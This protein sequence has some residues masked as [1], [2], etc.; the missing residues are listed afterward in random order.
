[1]KI[2]KLLFLTVFIYWFCPFTFGNAQQAELVLI[3]KDK[4][5]KEWLINE[6]KIIKI[7]H[8]SKGKLLITKG[9]LEGKITDFIRISQVEKPSYYNRRKDYQQNFVPQIPIN[10][11]LYLKPQRSAG[12][13]FL[14]MIGYIIAIPA[15]GI[16]VGNLV[17]ES[18]FIGP[19]IGIIGLSVGGP[20]I[21]YARKRKYKIKGKSWVIN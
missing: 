6:G 18:P 20:M 14:S 13:D 11:I 16:I 17:E 5:K 1:M 21:W 2:K 3:N 8:F 19:Q 15:L 7:A 4:P 12:K 9:I 10:N